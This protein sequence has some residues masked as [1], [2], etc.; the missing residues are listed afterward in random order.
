MISI[1]EGFFVVNVRNKIINIIAGTSIISLLSL[2][3]F[4]YY[5]KYKTY[6][7]LTAIEAEI[8]N[9]IKDINYE[10]VFE[11][12]DHKRYK[13]LNQ[14]DITLYY[15]DNVGKAFSHNKYLFNFSFGDNVECY[16]KDNKP[17]CKVI[18]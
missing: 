10:N 9:C 16:V 18:K 14:F 1:S 2:S 6:T 5:W 7:N 3:S 12:I 15:N 4:S 13:I 11:R 8:V 17:T